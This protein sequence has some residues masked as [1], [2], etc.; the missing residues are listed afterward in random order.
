LKE[1]PSLEKSGIKILQAIDFILR[2][3][4]IEKILTEEKL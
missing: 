2:V 4:Y 1:H 3:Y